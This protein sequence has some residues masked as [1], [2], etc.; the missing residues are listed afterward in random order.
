VRAALSARA[1]ETT[2]GYSPPTALALLDKIA[3]LAA[4]RQAG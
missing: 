3:D 1:T 2:A 4:W